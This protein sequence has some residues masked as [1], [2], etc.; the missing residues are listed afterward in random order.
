M[1]YD[2][3]VVRGLHEELRAKLQPADGER[4]LAAFNRVLDAAGI[5][6]WTAAEAQ[7]NLEIWDIASFPD[8]AFIAPPGAA[9]A[10]REAVEAGR[11]ELCD[12]AP[13]V[14]EAAFSSVDF[15]C[16]DWPDGPGYPL[17]LNSD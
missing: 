4:A 10:W 16:R 1:E 2:E 11:V 7:F 5:D 3:M 8:D 12:K 9:E 17:R 15:L 14:T 13:F 6:A